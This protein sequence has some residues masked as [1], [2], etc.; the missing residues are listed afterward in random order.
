MRT[1]LGPHSWRP[2]LRRLTALLVPL[3]VLLLLLGP[4]PSRAAEEFALVRNVQSGAGALSQSELKSIVAGRTKSWPSG[5][6]VVL[7]LGRSGSAELSWLA[8]SAGIPEGTL[9]SRINQEVFKGEMRKPVT[10]SS[11]KDCIAAV[12]ANAGALGVVRVDALKD[13]PADVRPVNPSAPKGTGRAEIVKGLV[14]EACNKDI[15]IEDL[16]Q[17]VSRAFDCD[18]GTLVTI[19]SCKIKCQKTP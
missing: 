18:P 19:A 2:W 11:E 6:G 10:A 9:M 12:A 8:N 4:A 7:V 14:K 17:S 16:T 13:L 3:C 5:V 15:P 1:R